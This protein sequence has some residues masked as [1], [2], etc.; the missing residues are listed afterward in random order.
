MKDQSSAHPKSI[1]LKC[2]SEQLLGN[3]AEDSADVEVDSPQ[4]HSPAPENKVVDYF[5]SDS[6]QDQ[7]LSA[8]DSSFN[9]SQTHYTCP[10]Q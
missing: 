7:L 3:P 2:S 5:Y 9:I 1:F 8:E 10:V 6:N 4:P